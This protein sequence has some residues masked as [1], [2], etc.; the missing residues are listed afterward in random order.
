MATF[1]SN[2]PGSVMLDDGSFVFGSGGHA[3]LNDDVWTDAGT[4][5]EYAF[6]APYDGF[7]AVVA[8]TAGLEADIGEDD[9]VAAAAWPSRLIPA[10]TEVTLR[11]VGS[12]AL[13]TDPVAETVQFYGVK[14]PFTSTAPTAI[15][16]A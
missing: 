5:A 4:A 6:T 16:L 12:D 13:A 9:A 15:T 1:T 11:V 14:K 10:G 2:K 7:L 8:T 3:T